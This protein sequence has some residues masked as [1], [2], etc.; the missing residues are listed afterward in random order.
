MIILLSERYFTLFI[1]E[2]DPDANVKIEEFSEGYKGMGVIE[3][4]FSGF[5]Y[6]PLRAIEGEGVLIQKYSQAK[7]KVSETKYME[8]IRGRIIEMGFMVSAL[9]ETVDEANK[10]FTVIRI[11]LA[12]FGL[13][14]LFI[15]AIGMANTMTVTLLE[16]TNEIGIMKSIGASNKDIGLMFL[17]ESLVMGFLGGVG[18]IGIGFVG[19]EIFNGILNLVARGF[20]GQSIDLFYTP[21]WFLA[22]VMVF[23]T[24]VGFATGIFPARRA[25]KMNPLQALRY[26]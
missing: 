25:A 11:I 19:T 24:F 26:K 7:V 2:A 12:V 16:R 20:G 18:G 8:E 17:M 15:S 14:A 10:V 9:A 1:E 4:D 21:P 6:I 22:F 23:S 13:I 5:A 3:D